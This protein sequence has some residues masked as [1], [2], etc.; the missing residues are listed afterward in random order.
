MLRKVAGEGEV[1]EQYVCTNTHEKTL[2]T[3]HEA[4][5]SRFPRHRMGPV[6]IVVFSLRRST[7]RNTKYLEALDAGTLVQGKCAPY[8]SG[9][10]VDPHSIFAS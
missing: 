6:D 10:P 7:T 1:T 4:P 5:I 8:A 2:L 3:N 9:W